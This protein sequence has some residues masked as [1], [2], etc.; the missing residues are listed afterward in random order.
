[1]TV[2]LYAWSEQLPTKDL[3]QFDFVY[4]FSCN[5][6][7]SLLESFH[8][9][10]RNDLISRVNKHEKK[11]NLKVQVADK[12]SDLKLSFTWF[13]EI[14]DLLSK[15]TKTNHKIV[16]TFYS[17]K[18]LLQTTSVIVSDKHNQFIV[19]QKELSL[20]IYCWTG[21]RNSTN[22]KQVRQKS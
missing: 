17:Q 22:F 7:A 4:C 14:E 18:F 19:V 6:K 15:T 13:C 8:R 12:S 20:M 2:L 9:L 11:K 16:E 1:M 5:L 21:E 3:R 10:L